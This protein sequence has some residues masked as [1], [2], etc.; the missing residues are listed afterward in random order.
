MNA[1]TV[2]AM[3][4]DESGSWDRHWTLCNSRLAKTSFRGTVS[5]NIQ[6]RVLACS[7]AQTAGGGSAFNFLSHQCF[8]HMI[9]CG[10]VQFLATHWLELLKFFVSTVLLSQLEDIEKNLN[11]G[12]L[13]CSFKHKQ[14]CWHCVFVLFFLF[15]C[16]DFLRTYGVRFY[17][18]FNA[19]PRWES[20]G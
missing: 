17:A 1:V 11:L 7:R 9:F 2:Q 13:L 20:H 10:C 6:R 14:I 5:P 19:C 18:W 8:C 3:R 16:M 4:V 12:N 15:A